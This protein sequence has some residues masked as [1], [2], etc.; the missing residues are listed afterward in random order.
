MST[1][2]IWFYMFTDHKAC[3]C[4]K[5][6]SEYSP[7]KVHTSTFA[8]LESAAFWKGNWS[9]KHNETKGHTSWRQKHH[10][11]GGQFSKAKGKIKEHSHFHQWGPVSSEQKLL[12]WSIEQPL[13]QSGLVW[14]QFPAGVEENYTKHWL[15]AHMITQ[16]LWLIKCCMKAY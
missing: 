6:C 1:K 2:S 13:E 9:L 7:L 4:F 3:L 14:V 11:E 5:Y 15:S 16:Q 8:V 10:P 12:E